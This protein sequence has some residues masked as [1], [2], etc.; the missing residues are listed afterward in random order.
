MA[1]TSPMTYSGPRAL[2]YRER[3]S[4]LPDQTR[5]W[6]N[7]LFQVLEEAERKALGGLAVGED[8]VERARDG[9]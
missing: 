4:Q 7:L 6:V 5:R 3:I 9:A 2:K 1:V 8:E